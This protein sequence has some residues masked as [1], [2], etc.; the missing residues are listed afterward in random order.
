MKKRVVVTYVEAGQGHIVTAEAISESLERLYGDEIEVV[1]DWIFRADKDKELINHEQFLIKEVKYANKHKGHLDMQ[2]AFMKTFTEQG[3][4]KFVY[5]NIFGNIYKKCIKHL[6]NLKP[7]A[8]VSTH[9]EPAFYSVEACRKNH[10]NKWLNIIYDPDHCV[11]GWW[12][13][14][15]D[16][17]ITN[18]SMATQE[19]LEEKDFAPSQ[20]KQVNFLSR[21][22]IRNFNLSKEECRIKHNIPLNKFTVILADGAYASAN[23]ESFT[24][25]LLKTEKEITIIAVAGKN[26]KVY[27]KLNNLI[28]NVPN[29]I[30]LIVLPFMT[31]IEEFYCASDLFITKAGPNAIMDSMFVN[32]PIMTNF[33]SGP[34]EKASNTLFTEYYKTGFYVKDKKKARSMIE[35]FIE[36]P[37]LLNEYR[38]NTY[39]FDKSKNGAD[40]IAKL[41]YESLQNPEE[42]RYNSYKIK[43]EKK[44]IKYQ[45]DFDKKVEKTTNKIFKAKTQKRRKELLSIQKE[46][47]K[48]EKKE[49]QN[50]KK[51]KDKTTKKS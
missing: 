7:D 2:F 38:Q 20:V 12:D 49:K 10:K 25:E 14:R 45:N 36:N 46:V 48:K 51:S 19:A 23:L 11:H 41:I 32:T 1:R 4:L 28:N 33:Y 34:I 37:S 35:N 8:V 13:N 15:C 24:N 5:K 50:L 21:N 18:N 17:L 6:E 43:L 31:N 26:E 30:T 3:T 47:F 42:Y 27:N 22:Q 9:F 40:E 39:Q 44:K 16:I 29:N